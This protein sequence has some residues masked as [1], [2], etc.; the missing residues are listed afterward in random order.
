MNSM[1]KPKQVLKS[2]NSLID[3][4][5]NQE[6]LMNLLFSLSPTIKFFL[7]QHPNLMDV[8]F[9]VGV[10]LIFWRKQSKPVTE[11]L[12]ELIDNSLDNIEI[13]KL[14]DSENFRIIFPQIFEALIKEVSKDKKDLIYRFTKNFIKDP[15]NNTKYLTKAMFILI[16]MTP[17]ANDVLSIFDGQLQKKWATRNKETY[18]KAE[19][20]VWSVGITELNYVLERKYSNETLMS[21]IDELFTYG[22]AGKGRIA[23]SGQSDLGKIT[24]FGKYFIKMVSQ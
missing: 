1:N 18:D 14:T 2:F 21:I 8:F 20:G 19:K 9:T 15:E 16:Q 6:T 22:I 5:S 12:L 10:F 23:Y 13:K 4:L 24:E 3:S 7:L 11:K 17:E